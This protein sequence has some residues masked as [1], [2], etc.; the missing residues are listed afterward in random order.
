MAAFEIPKL[1]F[2]GIANAALKR[3][4][5][6]IPSSDTNYAYATATAATVGVTMNDPA[7]NEVV[8]IA[9]GIVMVEAGEEINAGQQ[10]EVGTDGVA[11]VKD[12]GLAVGM[13]ITSA[14]AANEL[15]TV[16]MY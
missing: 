4:R 5:F 10:V 3:R 15:A 13:C 9:D 14:G 1:R 6:V 16:K 7:I 11:S 2:S 12:A 8:E